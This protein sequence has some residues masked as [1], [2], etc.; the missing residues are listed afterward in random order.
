MQGGCWQDNRGR[1]NWWW[2]GHWFPWRPRDNQQFC[3][4]GMC[5]R[6]SG[7]LGGGSCNKTVSL[8]SFLARRQTVAGGSVWGGT[9]QTHFVNKHLPI[10][11]HSRLWQNET[12]ISN[13]PLSTHLLCRKYL[14]TISNHMKHFSLLPNR[15][16][17]TVCLCHTQYILH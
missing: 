4:Q 10:T 11:W 1:N 16:D 13:Y 2:H 12:L 15:I 7:W 17:L 14:K 3:S 5:L 6:V 9:V 8:L